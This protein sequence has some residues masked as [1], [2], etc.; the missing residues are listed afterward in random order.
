MALRIDDVDAQRYRR[1]YVDDIFR[2]LERLGVRWT[3]GPRSTEEF[4]RD[5]SQRQQTA[6]YR[7][8][9]DALAG[10]GLVYACTC[11]RARLD[12]PPRGGCPGGCREASR[13]DTPDAAL[14]LAVPEGTRVTLSGTTIDVSR[15]VG[16]VVLWRRDGVPAY[17][18]VSVVEDARLG[19]THIVRG[20]DLLPSSAIQV[21]LAQQLGFHTV[22]QAQYV[23]HPLV[24]DA[25]GNK[26]SK[27][28]MASRREHP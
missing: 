5:W 8:A 7:A 1:E 28:T 13:L 16:D 19:T 20:E 12:G 26:L 23:H 6:R 25:E 3:I 22:A 11:S 24:R 9:V 27:S 14:R 18:L 17:H 2:A 4:E 15:E 21:H 10:R